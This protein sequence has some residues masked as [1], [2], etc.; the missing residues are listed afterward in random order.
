MKAKLLAS[1]IILFFFSF[2]MVQEALAETTMAGVSKDDTFVYDIATTWNSTDP[3]KP[4]PEEYVALQ[5]QEWLSLKVTGVDG[6]KVNI[7]TTLHYKNTTEETHEYSGVP[8][9]FVV[10]PNLTANETA[11]RQNVQGTNETILRTYSNVER[12][13]NYASANVHVGDETRFAGL[14]QVYV[15]KKT[16]V[17][18]EFREEVPVSFAEYDNGNYDVAWLNILIKLRDPTAWSSSP[19]GFLFLLITPLDVIP[20]AAAGVVAHKRAS[21]KKQKNIPQKEVVS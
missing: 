2:A 3:T 20:V 18:V 10:E 7:E 16:G 1:L 19:S 17:L 8:P 11:I 9:N 12:E 6:S 5:N 15:D 13:T 21:E 4:V 14:L